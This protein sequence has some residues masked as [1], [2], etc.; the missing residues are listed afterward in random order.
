MSSGAP[1]QSF[2][3]SSTTLFRGDP[4]Y[5]LWCWPHGSG[6]QLSMLPCFRRSWGGALPTPHSINYQRKWGLLNSRVNSLQ[7]V[8]V[9]IT[10]L[11]N[12]LLQI[13]DYCPFSFI[14]LL[15]I[16]PPRFFFIFFFLIVIIINFLNIFYL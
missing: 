15:D 4:C 6:K 16:N 12:S 1:P 14:L 11:F 13:H 9:I 7:F 2:I 3:G 5:K 10:R 8:I